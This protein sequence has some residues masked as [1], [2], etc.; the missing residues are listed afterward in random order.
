V[1]PSGAAAGFLEV[2]K[3]IAW[4]IHLDQTIAHPVHP[5]HEVLGFGLGG[6]HALNAVINDIELAPQL[7]EAN[8]QDRVDGQRHC[9]EN[10]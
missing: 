2:R 6:D 4:G 1:L 5:P 3:R 10:G 8:H 7:Q 9:D